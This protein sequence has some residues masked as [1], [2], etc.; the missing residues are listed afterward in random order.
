LH[1]ALLWVDERMA[2]ALNLSLVHPLASFRRTEEAR[3]ISLL[4][5]IKKPVPILPVLSDSL[6]GRGF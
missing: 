3:Q 6:L 2:K 4:M 5:H 1:G